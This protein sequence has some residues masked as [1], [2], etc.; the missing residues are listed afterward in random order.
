MERPV[1]F[2]DV[3]GVISLFDFAPD[4]PPDGRFHLIDGIPHLLSA[5]AGEHLRQLSERFETVWCT[6]WEEKAG[7][8]LPHLLGGLD[9]YPHLT[10]ERN[11]GRANGH[12]KLDAIEAYAGPR[13]P[14]AWLD[15]AHDDECAAWARRRSETGARTLLVGTDPAVGLTAAHVTELTA[16][17]AAL[18]A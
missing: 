8:H 5:S 11:P 4:R 13:R 16:W 7:E 12:W 18:S 2:V 9:S 14:L 15:D 17:A 1:L 3:D 6:G 10:F